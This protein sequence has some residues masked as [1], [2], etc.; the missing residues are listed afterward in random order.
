ME[1]NIWPDIKKEYFT[2]ECECSVLSVYAVEWDQ[3]TTEVGLML[4]GQYNT[5][6]KDRIKHI[7]S[8]LKYGHPWGSQELLLRGEEA[9]R[10]GE[11]LIENGHKAID[12]SKS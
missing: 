2:C 7:W 4:Y 10:L 9:V 5:S 3:Y 11:L 8:I 6:F 1:T 12:M